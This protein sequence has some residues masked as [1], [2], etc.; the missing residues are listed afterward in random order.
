MGREQ[1]RPWSELDEVSASE[2]VRDL[3]ALRAPV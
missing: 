2:L 3:E 1:L